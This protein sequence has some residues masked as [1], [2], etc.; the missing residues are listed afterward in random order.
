[1]SNNSDS[2]ERHFW[3]AKFEASC[4]C[5]NWQGGGSCQTSKGEYFSTLWFETSLP[6]L[7]MLAELEP[8]LAMSTKGIDWDWACLFK[9]TV[10]ILPKMEENFRVTS[11][12]FSAYL[13]VGCPSFKMHWWEDICKPEH[14]LEDMHYIISHTHYTHISH[15]L[16]TTVQ[17]FV[18]SPRVARIVKDL[19]M[20]QCSCI[21]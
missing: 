4:M 3:C 2:R 7:Q 18:L 8:P 5:A 14:E 13:K 9:R 15:T 1:M 6:L 12:H 19:K 17:N 20:L 11:H 21:S 16:S 10:L